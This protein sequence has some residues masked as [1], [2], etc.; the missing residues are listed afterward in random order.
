MHGFHLDSDIEDSP[1]IVRD[2]GKDKE[3]LRCCPL[4]SFPVLNSLTLKRIHQHNATHRSPTVSRRP[5]NEVNAK[6]RLGA[7]MQ[8]G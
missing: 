2:P 7:H 6:S 4:I 1:A 5:L 8:H 3:Q